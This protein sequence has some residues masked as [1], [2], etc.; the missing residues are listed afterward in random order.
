MATWPATLPAPSISGYGVDPVDQ[1]VRTGMEVGTQR[2]RRRSFA[3]VDTVPVQWTMSD[4]QMAIF[5]AWFDDSSEADGGA[6]WFSVSLLL[7]NGGFQTVEAKF[8]G[9][10]K[11]V[12]VPHMHW[13]VTGK[14]EVRYA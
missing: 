5:R 7:G 4:A 14:I 3:Q 2:V 10:Y 9:P 13:A 8:L 1:T 6:G 12:Y 11:A